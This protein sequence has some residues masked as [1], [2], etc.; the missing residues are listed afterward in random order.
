MSSVVLYRKYRPSS[1]SDIVGQAHVVRT[2]AGALT[3]GRIAHGYLFTG[4]RGTGKTTTA[5]ILAK[6]VNCPNRKE[7]EFEPCNECDSCREFSNLSAMD[8]IEIDA[9]SNR[10]IDEI[11][12]LK[13]GIKFVPTSS[14]YKV[15]IIDEVHMLTKEAFNALLK[16]LEEP[17]GHAIFILAT[18]E[19]EKVPPTILSRVQKFDFRKFTME[20]MMLRLKYLAKEEK[21]KIDDD[22][23]RLI[24]QSAE[25]GLRDAE[26]LLDQLIS[27]EGKEFGIEEVEQML[28]VVSFRTVSDFMDILLQKNVS[29]ALDFINKTAESGYD[30]REFAKSCISYLRRLLIIKIDPALEPLISKE[31]AQEQLAVIKAQAQNVSMTDIKRLMHYFLDARE[32]M[33]KTHHLALPLEMAAI[34]FCEKE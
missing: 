16:T 7:K 24:A 30:L 9:A 31:L 28:G 3:T 14:K 20:E 8:L 21:L 27:F 26:S 18:T 5:R 33:Q 19:V 22:A 23:L 4:P 13:E 15:F 6:A 1:F 29:A 17:P 2:L 32:V 25:G 34:A 12:E 11:R 10:G